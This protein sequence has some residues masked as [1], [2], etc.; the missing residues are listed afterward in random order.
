MNSQSLV[1]IWIVCKT[2]IDNAV[3]ASQSVHLLELAGFVQR[4]DNN[5]HAYRF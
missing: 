1:P 5:F 3:L 2:R 4:D